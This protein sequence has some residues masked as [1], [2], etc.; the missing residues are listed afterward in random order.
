[1]SLSGNF[2]PI[3]AYLPKNN[4]GSSPSHDDAI[5]SKFYDR[6]NGKYIATCLIS[7][8]DKVQF[9]SSLVT[10]R[11]PKYS[12]MHVAM[13]KWR[14]ICFLLEFVCYLRLF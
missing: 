5:T 2:E 10:L 7:P 3:A 12:G 11:R 9:Q 14:Q 4:S 6:K 1:M 8:E 13:P